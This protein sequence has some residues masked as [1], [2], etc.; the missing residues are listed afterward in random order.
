MKECG[1]EGVDGDPFHIY[2]VPGS[3]NLTMNVS[4][5]RSITVISSV[6]SLDFSS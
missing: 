6:K 2:L 4:D 1:P 3:S 5:L